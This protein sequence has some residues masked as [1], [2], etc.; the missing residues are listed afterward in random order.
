MDDNKVVSSTETEQNT[1]DLQEE[2]K[3]KTYTRSDVEAIKAAERK[4]IEDKYEAEK[5]E[6]ERLAKMNADEKAKYALEKETARANKA[7]SELNAFK[8]KDQAIN[9]AKE[10]GINIGL[11]DVIDFAHETA[12]TINSKIDSLEKIFKD[13]VKE[14]IK[15]ALKEKTP[16]YV[17]DNETSKKEVSRASF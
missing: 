10:K 14:G 7:E 16:K 13:A 9:I 1:D 12:E 5:T 17:V 15:D 6:A 2:K 3:E 11:L 4:R 8:L